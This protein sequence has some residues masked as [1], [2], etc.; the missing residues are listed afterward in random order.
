[1]LQESPLASADQAELAGCHDYPI[2]REISEAEA[3]AA[4]EINLTAAIVSL[5]DG[6]PKTLTIGAPGQEHSCKASPHSRTLSLPSGPFA[7]LRHR[8]LDI[9]LRDW[10]REQTGIGLGYAEQLYTFGDRG[11]HALPEDVGLHVVSIGYLALSR[12]EAG[13]KAKSDAHWSR[14]YHHFPWEDWRRG[15]PAIL[16]EEIEPRLEAWAAAPEP[17]GAPPRALSRRDRFGICFGR[18]GN[19]DEEKVL[20]RYELLYQ[21]GLVEEALRDGREAAQAWG[22]LP[23]FGAPMQFDHRRIVATAM[24][25]LRGKMKYRPVIFELMPKAFTLLELQRAV[26]AILGAFLHKQNFRRLVETGGL[27]EPTG[28]VREQTGGRPAR[29][30]RFRRN[31]LLE[32]PSPGM[33]VRMMQMG[34]SLNIL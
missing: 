12:I 14:W 11:R 28:E 15:K 6:E 1:M 24:S 33:R 23:Q 17:S 26:E 31:V 13:L 22:D 16:A 8:T 29:L 27:V 18:D 10:V 2:R 21:A 34:R 32:R 25:R 7:P 3:E 9:G 20:E 4:V 5:E 19:W 30:F